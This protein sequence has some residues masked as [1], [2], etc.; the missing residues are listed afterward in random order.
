MDTPTSDLNHDGALD[1]VVANKSSSVSVCLGVGDGT[2]QPETRFSVEV[3]RFALTAAPVALTV[4]DL[5]GDGELDIVTVNDN[6]DDVSV[7]LGSG[8]GAFELLSTF[9][10]GVNPEEGVVAD[11]N[12]DGQLDIVTANVASHDLSVLIG[13]GNGTFQTQQRYAAGTG[14]HRVL[15]ADFN[16]DQA[17][18]LITPGAL[19]LQQPLAP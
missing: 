5:N 4:V 19:L 12:G 14:A 10:V 6:A 11:L 17:P 8:S 18:D 15:V 9:P 1:L 16:G 3:D 2:F 13:L 7:L